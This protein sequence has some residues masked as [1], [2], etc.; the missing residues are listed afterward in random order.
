MPARTVE[1]HHDAIER[2]SRGHLIE[3]HLHALPVDAGQDQGVAF[4]SVN[5]ACRRKCTRG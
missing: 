4:A 3:K 1:N 2:M 5:V